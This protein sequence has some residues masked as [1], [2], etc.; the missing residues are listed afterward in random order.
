MIEGMEIALAAAVLLALAAALT[1]WR[2]QARRAAERRLREAAL[3]SLAHDLRTPLTAILGAATALES[4]GANLTQDRRESLAATAASGA[5]E[6]DRTLGHL[7]EARR[8]R[9]D[10]RADVR[11]CAEAALRRAGELEGH[12]V[13]IQIAGN[14]A[15]AIA[16]PALLELALANLIAN[17]A[18]HGPRGGAIGVGA[19]AEG[20]AIVLSVADEGPGAPPDVRG[21]RS[22]GGLGLSIARDFAAA[23]GGRLRFRDAPARAEIVLRRART[24]PRRAAAGDNAAPVGRHA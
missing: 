6:L 17:A 24:L 14:A 23:M 16:D 10:E 2:L 19:R 3:D 20:G 9:M 18:R 8:A 11:A 1:A 13:T 4:L 5:R 15:F 12:E 7:L 21:R 22:G